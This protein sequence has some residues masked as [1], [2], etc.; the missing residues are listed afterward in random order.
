MGSLMMLYRPICP[1]VCQE[2]HWLSRRHIRTFLPR[3]QSG[4][5]QIPTF[6]PSIGTSVDHFEN[7]TLCKMSE[8]DGAVQHFRQYE[9]NSTT[10]DVIEVSGTQNSSLTQ[11]AW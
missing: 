3:G 7:S 8:K 5:Q 9:L 11:K 1:E 10:H 4:M 6:L 2:W